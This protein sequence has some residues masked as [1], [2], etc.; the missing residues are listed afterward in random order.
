MSLVFPG[1][2]TAYLDA[3][4]RTTIS[5]DGTW[6]RAKEVVVGKEPRG[7]TLHIFSAIKETQEFILRPPVVKNFAH[8]IPS[9]ITINP[10]ANSFIFEVSFT[11]TQRPTTEDF[12]LR[13]VKP[14]KPVEES[15][16]LDFDYASWDAYIGG[17]VDPDPE[18]LRF[19][20]SLFALETGDSIFPTKSH[21]DTLNTYAK[22]V[23]SAAGYPDD[24]AFSNAYG[25]IIEK[26][27][28]KVLWA[29]NKHNLL[30]PLVGPLRFAR[31]FSDL[32]DYKPPGL[33]LYPPKVRR[34]VLAS[35]FEIAS[36]KGT[37]QGLALAFQKL[38]LG[39][40]SVNE[41]QIFR[42]HDKFAWYVRIP[43][44]VAETFN[45]DF[46]GQ[47]ALYHVDAYSQVAI[48]VINEEGVNFFTNFS[49]VDL[50]FV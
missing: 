48:Q 8:D 17:G 10:G 47:F 23:T 20:I 39:E 3:S 29:V 38:A 30:F 1:S 50:D 49:Y 27:Y 9:S 32:I 37:R 35:A 22:Y 42:E 15:A 5:V 44:Y 25:F 34:Q 26:M 43:P 14:D 13:F 46:L 41:L 6:Q 19:E 12:L 31:Q 7:V 21:L 40:V 18:E 16:Y 24:R 2:A 11:G 4:Y 28:D 33:N 45:I 36:L